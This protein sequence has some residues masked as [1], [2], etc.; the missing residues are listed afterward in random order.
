[1]MKK[2]L[3][4][5]GTGNISMGVTKRLLAQGYEVTLF[6]RGDAGALAPHVKVIQGDRHNRAEFVDR[7]KTMSFDYAIDMICFTEQDAKDDVE[8]LGNVDQFIMCSTGAVYGVISPH[9]TPIMEDMPRNPTWSYGVGKK[10]AEDYFLT[11]HALHQF[12]VTIIRPTF[13][14]GHQPLFFRQFMLDNSWIDRIKKGK[15]IITGNPY[16]LR[17]FLHVDD[18]APAFADAL[19]NPRCL[20]QVY[21]MVALRPYN[22]E[23]FHRAMMKALGREVEMVEAP[24]DLLKSYKLP[25]F[26][27]FEENWRYNGYYSGDKIARDIPTFNPTINL[28]QGIQQTLDF[29]EQGGHIPNSD[30]PEFAWEDDMIRKL[31]SIQQL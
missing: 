15:P 2:V 4:I 21:N 12:P 14:Y 30:A 24:F 1:M 17:N 31:Q 20:G 18:A 25:Y 19:G 6:K 29:L 11:Q 3:I 27:S 28:E 13:T 26:E 23:E 7:L 22:W 5:G 10:A 9:Y 16:V 8:A